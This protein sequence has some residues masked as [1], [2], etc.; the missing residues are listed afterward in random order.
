[1]YVVIRRGPGTARPAGTRAG[2]CTDPRA[3]PL[4]YGAQARR[5]A[6][7]LRLH[8]GRTGLRGKRARAYS[9]N[10]MRVRHPA[11]F[12]EDLERLFGLLATRAIQP[13]VAG[14]ISFDEVAEAHRRLEAGGLEGKLILCPNL[15]LRGD[16]VRA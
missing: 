4:D 5:A 10:V 16:R 14:R 9:I 1:M 13:R 11:W 2:R 7:R 15:P 8:G 12:R 6:L 3:T